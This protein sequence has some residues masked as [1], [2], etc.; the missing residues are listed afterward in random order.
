MARRF[1]IFGSII[2]LA[3]LVIAIIAN[4]RPERH[5]FDVRVLGTTNNA[6]DML[7]TV[8]GISNVS[9]KQLSVEFVVEEFKS[10]AWHQS[11]VQSTRTHISWPSA[12][13]YDFV[14]AVP[15]PEGRWRLMFECT[16]IPSRLQ[17][18]W[19]RVLD[20]LRID[21]SPPKPFYVTQE[22]SPLEYQGIETNRRSPLHP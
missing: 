12:P 22:L 4:S 3:G 9:R 11:F 2:A 6:L 10:N 13:G 8:V 7:F 1:L 14:V 18:K 16:A 20:W 5:T 15:R 21:R 17:L 19:N